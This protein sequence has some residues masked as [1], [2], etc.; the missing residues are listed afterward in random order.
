MLLSRGDPM[1]FLERPISATLLAITAAI[2]VF[3]FYSTIRNHRRAKQA[4][5]KV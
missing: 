1:V 2:L 5:T 3:A 4:E